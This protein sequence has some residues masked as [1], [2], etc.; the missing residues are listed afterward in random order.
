MHNLRNKVNRG[1]LMKN[2]FT[3]GIN[4]LLAV[5]LIA[6]NTQHDKKMEQALENAQEN[7]QELEKVFSHYEKD[8]TK[9]AAARFLIENMSYHFTQEQY[10]T[11]SEK[12]RYRPDVVNFDGFQSVKSHCDSLTR[13]GYKIKTHNKYDISTL[14]SHF[15]ID[16]I[17]LAF[18]VW[19][20]PW[21][22]KCFIQ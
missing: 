4:I 19:Q 15:L 11:S 14:D 7:R 21:A 2:L 10:Y 18:T 3:K 17:E 8:S 16:N 5:F 6:C 1:L 9:L 13:R 20:K 22:K 12:E